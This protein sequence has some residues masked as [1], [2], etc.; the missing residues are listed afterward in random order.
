M[1]EPTLALA[2]GSAVMGYVGQNDQAQAQMDSAGRQQE[3]M[4][5]QI[6]EQQGQIQDQASLETTERNKQGMIERAQMAT[7]A[8]ESGALGISSDRLVMDSFMQEGQDVSSLERNKQNALKQ[9]QWEGKQAQESA[10]SK[11]SVAKGSAGNLLT[12][13]LQIGTAA[14]GYRQ[15][16]KAGT[17][18]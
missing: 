18:G 3:L 1:C 6:T 16:V 17:T 14:E 13:G 7:I 11:I 12:T 9:T 8:G 4:N 10:K 2:I 15:R 5:Q